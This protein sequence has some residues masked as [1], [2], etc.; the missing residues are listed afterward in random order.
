[1][2]NKAVWVDSKPKYYSHVKCGLTGKKLKGITKLL[3]S[4]FYP[5]YTDKFANEQTY[6]PPPLPVVDKDKLKRWKLKPGGLKAGTKLA[7]DLQK[8]LKLVQTHALPI[9]CMFNTPAS[10]A[11]FN[12]AL[13]LL[14]KPADKRS[15]RALVKS[16]PVSMFWMKMKQKKWMPIASELPVRHGTLPVGTKLDMVVMD[17]EK[18]MF[19]VEVKSGC[20]SQYKHTKVKMS[21]PFND[22]DDSVHNQHQLQLSASDEMWK[23]TYP[24]LKRLPPVVLRIHKD[25]V[26][27][28]PLEKWAL[29]RVSS[30]FSSLRDRSP[31]VKKPIPAVSSH[32]RTQ[33]RKPS[34]CRQANPSKRKKRKSSPSRKSAT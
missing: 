9:E 25:Q 26:E 22:K 29:D 34:V 13:T 16:Y 27:L 6:Y 18:N 8:S 23:H 20:K 5:S 14:K 2:N 17:R 32:S 21:Y 3:K 7:I 30:L 31:V 19:Q 24:G 1:M 10:D 12:H 33:K 11:L 28:L 4:N 15:L